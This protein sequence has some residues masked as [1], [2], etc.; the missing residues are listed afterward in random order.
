MS[1]RTI[2]LFTVVVWIATLGLMAEPI[3]VKAIQTWTGSLEDSSL[4]REMPEGGVITTAKE[5]GRLV[6]AW[7]VAEKVP[8]V[9]FAQQIV[10]VAT[11]SGSRLNL[12]ASLD[13]KGDLRA[14]A[15]ATRDLRPGF[16]YAIVVVSKD[17]VRTVNGEELPR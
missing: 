12:K 2:S 9:D 6:K 11:T 10:L 14:L 3:P 5:F 13:D 8:A 4:V 16:R 17:K 1:L 15:R 7:G